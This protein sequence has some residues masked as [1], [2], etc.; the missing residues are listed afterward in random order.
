MNIENNLYPLTLPQE[1]FYYDYLLN[2]DNHKYNMGGAFF[3]NGEL[4]IELYR[5]AYNYAV[6]Y[7]DGMRV[8]F[9]KSGEF[10]YQQF[11][12]D[13][14]YEIKYFDFRNSNNAVENALE[15]LLKEYKKPLPPVDSMLYSEIILRTGDFQYIIGPKFHHFANDAMGR[16]IFN[17]AVSTAYNSYLKNGV[18]PELKPFSYIDFIN[19]D[20]EYRNSEAYKNSFEYWKQKFS[21]LPEPFLFTS[22]KRSVKNTSQHT[23]RLT[24]NLHRICFE[25]VHNLADETGATTYQVIL[26][27]LS[28]ILYK[29]YNNNEFI[30]GMPVLN[31][32][33]HKFRNTP[34]L[35]M[36]MMGLRLAI[37]PDDTFTELIKL[38]KSETREGYRHQRFPLR[39]ILKHL[40]STNNF[41]G[42]LFD[43]TVVYRNGSYSQYL[44]D[45]KLKSV[46]FDSE[47]RDESLSIEID[48]YDVE[49]NVN[50]FF[51]YNPLVISKEEINQ[52]VHGFETVLIGLALS[53]EKKIR[54][55]VILND[56]EAYKVLHEF[57]NSAIEVK[58][59]KTII[60]QFEE[61]VIKKPDSNAVICN[62]ESIS[63]RLLD[64]KSNCIANYILDNF[65]IQQ[66]DIICLAANRSI[67]S[68]AAI[69]GIMK[70]GAAYLPVD[71][72]YPDERIKYII[73][74]SGAQI[75]LTDT[76]RLKGLC[77]NVID[78]NDIKYSKN[79]KPKV[80]LIP[81]NLAYIIYTSGST[82]LPKGVMIE[83]TQFMNTFVNVIDRFGIKE[84]DR[85][86]QFASFGFD[87]S[88]MEIFEA[89]LTGAALIIAAKDTIRDTD[90]F[91]SYVTDKE[92]T[93]ATLPPVYLNVLDHAALPYIRTL[94][95]AG[96]QAISEDVNYY[97][98]NKIF[99][100]A[101]GPTE[102][103]VC[104]SSYLAEKGIKYE[105]S[106]PIGKPAGNSK[107]YIL[108]DSLEPLPI[109]FEGEL[110]ISGSGIARGYL[111]NKELTEKKF[112]DNPFQAGT[113]LYRTGDLAKWL[114]DGNIEYLGRIDDQV[115]I[116]GNRIEPGEIE[117]R[118]SKYKGI[119]EVI[120]L[121]I[122][123]DGHKELAAFIISSEQVDVNNIRQYLRRY[124]PEYMIPSHYIFPDNIPVTSNGKTDKRVL[125]KL[126]K[127]NRS[128]KTIV[129]LDLTNTEKKLIPIFE[130]V[131]NVHPMGPDDNFF[132]LG[133]E[134]LKITRL[135]SRIKKELKQNIAFKV[136]FDNPTI[137]G[138]AAE[139]DLQ[140]VENIEDITLA[141]A[142]EYYN[143][144]HAQKR[145]WILAQNK[146]NASAYHMPV[147][148][149][150]EGSLNIAL[151]EE[152]LDIIIKRHEALHTIYNVIGGV[153]Y[154]KVVYNYS[155]VFDYADVSLSTDSDNAARELI[156][157]KLI[158]PF[159]LEADIPVRTGLIKLGD[160][161][162][163]LLLVIH[164]IAGDGISIGII[165]NELSELY[166]GKF[167][168]KHPELPPL[169]IQ[170]KD[171]CEYEKSVIENNKYTA[172]KQYWLNKLQAP[173]PV[174]ELP[175]DRP[176]PPLKTYSGSY[177]F[178][179]IDSDIFNDI[180][181]FCKTQNI[182]VFIFFVSV[183]NILLHK[184]SSQEDIIVGS[185]VAGRNHQ[186]LENQVGLYLNTVAVRNEV[187]SGILI[188]D[189]LKQ[190]KICTTEAVTNSNFPFDKLIEILSPERDTSRTPLFD[191]LV[192]LQ[193][194]PTLSLDNIKTS[195][196]EAE[197]KVNKF[198]LTFTFAESKQD[199][200]FTIGY[201]TDLF[202]ELRINNIAKHINNLCKSIISNPESE[203]GD[204]NLLDNDE[205]EYL[206]KI[207]TGLNISYNKTANIAARFE[208][209]AEKTP[210]SIALIVKDKK[211]TFKELNAK[212]NKISLEIKRLY[213]VQPDDVIGIISGRSEFMII[214]ML[215]ILK[216]GAAYLPIDPDYPAE[217][218]AFMLNN[219]N[220]K[221]LLVEDCYSGIAGKAA[222]INQPAPLHILNITAI[223]GYISE[224]PVSNIESGNLAYVIYTSGSTGRP[225]GVMVEHHS[226]YNLVMSLGNV[227]GEQPVPLNIA[228]VS[229]FVF[230]ASVKQIFY[231]L[232]NGHCLN[233]IPD[234]IKTSGR[235]LLQYYYDHKI[236]VS[237][238]TPVHLEIILEELENNREAYLPS[239]FVIGG[240][241]LMHSTIKKLYSRINGMPPVIT[242]VYGPTECCDVSAAF[243][244]TPEL[245]P[246]IEAP[247]G[248]LPV[249]K[250]LNNVC[251]YILDNDYKKVPAGV[252]G[253]LFIAGEGVA[254]GYINNPALTKEKYIKVNGH[255]RER[256]YRTG[257]TGRYLEDGNI[258]LSGR[259]DDQIKLRGFRIEL[260]EIE[261]TI[262]S[263]SS[264]TSAAVI[265]FGN[266]NDKEIAAY[267]C[268]GTAISGEELRQFMSV[269]LPG[270][271]IPSYF[272]QL[273]ALPL[274]I[275]GKV[276]KNILPLPVKSTLKTNN[277]EPTG[278]IEDKLCIIW[279]ELLNVEKVYPSDN[280][281]ALGGHSLIA[282]R[283]TSKIHKLF[284]VELNI[285]EVFQ[286]PD[287]TR[288][289]EVIRSKNP[290]LFTSIE[291][292]EEREYYPLS[293]SQ[294]R[295][296]LLSMLEGHSSQYNL[297]GA[298]LLKGYLNIEAL[299]KAFNMIIDRHEILRTSFIEI[300]GEPYQVITDKA[301]TE[302]EVITYSGINRTKDVLREMATA[303]F[304]YEFNLS[305]LPL[306]RMRIVV[307][308]EDEHLLLLNM[309]HIISDG[310][311]LDVMINEL[312]YFYNAA[313][314]ND[315]KFLPPLKIQ[316]KDYAAW[317]N[318][319]LEDKSI[320]PVKDYWHNKLKK[321]YTLLDLPVDYKRPEFY[322]DNGK[323]LRY[324]LDT[325]TVRQL[326]KISSLQNVSLY[327]TLLSAVYI[328]LYKYSGEKDIIIG[329]PVAGRQHEDLNDQIGFYINT[330]ALR[331]EINPESTFNEYLQKVKTTL[332]E[333]LDNQIYPF[334]RLVNEL[335]VE[336]IQ[337]RNP[338]FDVMVSWMVNDGMEMKV[339]FNGIEAVGL[340][341]SINSS[342]FD[343]TFLFSEIEGN[344][345]GAIE[346]NTSLFKIES[347][348]RMADNF[349]QL[350]KSITL[351]A[352]EK[353]KNLEIIPE[354]EKEKILQQSHAISDPSLH[355]NVI[356]MFYTQ[357][358]ESINNT[359]LRY[360]ESNISYIE[361]DTLSNCIANFIIKQVK[362]Q[363]DDIITVIVE[364][365]IYTVAAML[366]IMKSGA[367]YLPV[368]TDIPAERISF[369]I[370]NSSSR[371]VIS[372]IFM[373]EDISS[374]INVPVLDINEALREDT[375]APSVKIN[376]DSLA[377]II[378]TSG[379]TGVPKGVMVEHSALANLIETVSK[380]VYSNYDAG[381]NELMI[382][383]FAFDV[384][385][386]QIFAS[387]CNGNI[388]HILDKERRL[389]P[390][391][392]IKYLLKNEINVADLTPSLFSI[393]LEE[394]FDKTD[395]PFLKELFLGSEALPYKLIKIFYSN[396]ANHKIN[397]TNFYGPTECCVESSSYKFNPSD[398]NENYDIAPIG[399]PIL[400][401]QIFILDEYLNICPVGVPGEICISGKGLARGY[402]N[403]QG[404]TEDKFIVLSKMG[405]TR[406]YKTGD[407]GKLLPDGNIEFLGRF[408]DQVKVRG[409][410]VELQEVEKYFREIN[411]IKEC[412]VILYEKEDIKELAVYFTSGT[413]LNPQ[414]LKSRLGHFLPAYMVPAYFTQLD[415]IPLSSNGKV[416][417]KKLPSP[418]GIMRN[419]VVIAPK[420]NIDISVLKIC[421]E[422]LKNE[423]I[424]L[425]DNFFETGGN[426]LSAVR[427]ISRIQKEFNVELPLK[428]IFYNPV[429]I[430]IADNI[431]NLIAPAEQICET[432]GE[433]NFIVPMSDD[434]LEFLSN[435]QDDDEE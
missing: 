142:K 97:K 57:N 304:N 399:K 152:S 178:Y 60:E 185:P 284:N 52:F 429:L 320:L 157:D 405:N 385:I 227:Y 297:P 400:N 337:N 351:N 288:L 51:N 90:N 131:L 250:P 387:I 32:S 264:I 164:H 190:V 89:L 377:Y 30:L 366:G 423:S 338:L 33:N 408:D 415:H 82:G 206:E 145:M 383:S 382:N 376:P 121:D 394:G 204:I 83:H 99:I 66:E 62:D 107:V 214:G 340:E 347:I 312:K 274:T 388:L 73:D 91:I 14:N 303:Y 425:A 230:D 207:A 283:L 417:K 220:A 79:D 279:Q 100:N 116:N 335:E 298:F 193:D 403:D 276:N 86:L 172:E 192:Q 194:T 431:R 333:A 311:S 215:G 41:T 414:E 306:I 361:L 151:L 211:F 363:Q 246:E 339:D 259:N 409:Y 341:F 203:L 43:V 218:I 217:R 87:A 141:S 234:E 104:T 135:I 117:A 7:F 64:E 350:L 308:S 327:M 120:V 310:W 8:R 2:G 309:H 144:S 269:T 253:E 168:G 354:T 434:E 153:P 221:V 368:M 413:T 418:A 31:R 380:S 179:D 301:D 404:K 56:F 184:Y 105:N 11:D 349:C 355:T 384:S 277:E 44:G 317:Q 295:L 406:I 231:S 357:A 397:V 433:D 367:A 113:R 315:E 96:E 106:V 373:N 84:T 36:N 398:L 302:I 316:Y 85:V 196:Y 371:A 257:D 163:I 132:E 81:G 108:S 271:M 336:R 379:S 50:I 258:I 435:F 95:T 182:S 247:F 35:F 88:V 213:N 29:C 59:K 252:T 173:L 26:A 233:I 199:I 25:S 48:E 177:L 369:I 5:Q 237:D 419:S 262:M 127:E 149:L 126:A 124:L 160:N 212:A 169:R 165:L 344:V 174:L 101:Y 300:D 159:N 232:L 19:D 205:N 422:V 286:N 133:G 229:P 39:D 42:D 263:H 243:N 314:S 195:F 222:D 275:N 343:L 109:G 321:P 254:R 370:N 393:M 432:K 287:I 197:F 402:L 332:T 236:D 156:K 46:T 420:D 291:N 146:D 175:S 331:S 378:Y 4:N 323:L 318:K 360:G 292:I 219:S 61:I 45:T 256:L 9:I 63:Y 289:A 189:F 249:G 98:E 407:K 115:K 329:S 187:K 12:E 255:T 154:Q 34:G 294:K 134:S 290:S 346:F 136:F 20:L 77:K 80:N 70:T 224:N 293:H 386:K 181:V 17:E 102:N 176:R 228:L 112:V 391:E 285:W 140:E 330:L 372:D 261:N 305:T 328:L 40:R 280:F 299:Q 74:N 139:L 266:G 6:K 125:R 245:F 76:P 53:P 191:V 200:S 75:L 198:D 401:E 47:M 170:Y 270:Y 21:S 426:S 427:V 334:D 389:D 273:Q 119:K 23:E 375:S 362:P 242:N 358:R 381:M 272:I 180:I 72:D 162:H 348:K 28:I 49:G 38:I 374:K 27:I 365:P 138:I 67:D 186:E 13:V 324:T 22:K 16:S 150:L 356:D 421:S 1:A 68:I 129:S 114:P 161:K 123:N 148:L 268:S 416:D 392:I 103:S 71:T 359:A 223:D 111:N 424:S 239:R 352:S 326:N 307:L 395:K 226:L 216:A 130:D 122:L 128:T 209:Q 313:I 428:E 171:Y 208:E 412:A 158:K 54:D 235:K 65:T 244:I 24:L 69:L 238:G 265:S 240:Q 137:R 411:E 78:L 147:S 92:V 94:I 325:E 188:S 202:N 37:K 155:S 15:F 267:Y 345:F 319:I 225:K 3:V 353:I 282:I 342:M 10:L 296:W 260:S 241:Q 58:T 143:L 118:I 430:S 281:F 201:N 210:E 110:C 183:I 166:N 93:V 167:N 251:I 396:P 410:R 18:F 390:R 248:M 55:I 322:S 278:I 364:N